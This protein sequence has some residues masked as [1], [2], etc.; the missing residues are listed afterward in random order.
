MP[1]HSSVQQYV[2]LPARGVVA[3]EATA[4]REVRSYLISLHGSLNTGGALQRPQKSTVR[5]RVLDSIHC[6]SPFLLWGGKEPFLPAPH[7]PEMLRRPTEPI[8]RI[9]WQRSRILDQKSIWPDQASGF[10]RQFLV[11][12]RRWMG[13]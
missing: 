4:S 5:M 8:R 1:A 10:S 2:M 13:R 6:A 9:S 11:A 12:M 3:T 7:K